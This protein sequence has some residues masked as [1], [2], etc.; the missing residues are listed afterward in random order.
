MLSGIP[1]TLNRYLE[2][3]PCIALECLLDFGKGRLV[4]GAT[5]GFSSSQTPW[6]A[7]RHSYWSVSVMTPLTWGLKDKGS[8]SSGMPV[9]VSGDRSDRSSGVYLEREEKD[10]K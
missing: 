4:P 6:G 10:K 5:A 1:E 9:Q 8:Y 7:L 2:K 3:Y